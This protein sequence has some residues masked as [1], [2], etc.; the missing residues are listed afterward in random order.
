VRCQNDETE[1]TDEFD[2]DGLEPRHVVTPGGADGACSRDALNI[3]DILAGDRP[4]ARRR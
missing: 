2:D 4:T 3:A 1:Q